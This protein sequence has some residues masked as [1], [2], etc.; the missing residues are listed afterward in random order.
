M[1]LD[2]F[3]KNLYLRLKH[4]HVVNSTGYEPVWF[5]V[6]DPK[7]TVEIAAFRQ[8]F[9]K[10]LEIQGLSPMEFNVA[11]A[12]WDIL[13]SDVDWPDI[14]EADEDS[15][16]QQELLDT[17][18][19]VIEPSPDCNRLVERLKETLK[20]AGQME[21]SVLLVS[22]FESLHGLMRPGSIEGKL[23]GCFACPTLFFY[24]GKT[25]GAAGLQFLNI[26]PVD[27]NYH[28]EHLMVPE[29]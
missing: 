18:K 9:I 22:G 28:S 27:S 1:S 16:D 7:R 23:N 25:E 3:K 17:L 6:Y 20:Q 2:E 5:L 21:K 24:P 12:L 19:A 26:H 14:Q 8:S 15:L 4:P 13:E 10:Y 11:N 29:A